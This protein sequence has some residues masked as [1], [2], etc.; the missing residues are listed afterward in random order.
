MPTY[1]QDTCDNSGKGTVDGVCTYN[2]GE[3]PPTKDIVGAGFEHGLF[4]LRDKFNDQ[5][6][7][8]ASFRVGKGSAVALG[9]NKAD[10]VGSA[11]KGATAWKELAEHIG[12]TSDTIDEY[13][14]NFVPESSAMSAFRRY[15]AGFIITKAKQGQF[16]AVFP[17]LKDL[18]ILVTAKPEYGE[19]LFT[20]QQGKFGTAVCTCDSEGCNNQSA[21]DF[22]VDGNK[23]PMRLMQFIDGSLSAQKDAVNG[24][25]SDLLD[26]EG[27][28]NPAQV[29]VVTEGDVDAIMKLEGVSGKTNK[30][31]LWGVVQ[32]YQRLLKAEADYKQ[33]LVGDETFNALVI[34]AAKVNEANGIAGCLLYGVDGLP[35]T[36]CLQGLSEDKQKMVSSATGIAFEHFKV[37]S[38][39][40]NNMENPVPQEVVIKISFVIATA[41]DFDLT[42]ALDALGVP[43]AVEAVTLFELVVETIIEPLPTE[44]E[45]RE[46]YANIFKLMPEEVSIVI[47]LVS[48]SSEGSS[49]R[50]QG[51]GA[52]VSATGTSSNA[53]KMDAAKSAAEDTGALEV[54]LKA[55]AATKFAN[56][57]TSIAT[58]PQVKAD[59][60]IV[61]QVANK[62][63]A[64]ELTAAF[65][66]KLEDGKA[67]I[68]AAAGATGADA[69]TI[70]EQIPTPMPT[71]MPTSAP[72]MLP[73]GF[74]FFPTAMPTGEPTKM[75]TPMPTAMP[76]KM[77]TAMPTN[78]PTTTPTQSPTAM[79]TPVPP[80]SAPTVSP[81]DPVFA[82]GAEQIAS[83][84]LVVIFAMLCISVR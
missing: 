77:P 70:V 2:D 11:C 42:G 69:S 71:K 20:A 49:R 53:T 81:T 3:G 16:G 43:E 30:E 44:Q 13:C 9:S 84:S 61:Q 66:K 25:V 41:A 45:A 12:H 21:L 40:A 79:P 29:S 38:E 39:K 18:L 35:N 5:C 24:I 55:T 46:V 80:T 83:L 22:I 65:V 6:S 60:Q 47:T 59:L 58:Q 17:G 50:L 37:G 75:P 82:A 63:A 32:D 72:T 15:S 78:G 36:F 73:A 23:G 10:L 48:S 52:L 19:C 74:T 33:K 28:M 64:N 1:L 14:A 57:T 76:T 51:G 26:A 67:A 34:D 31:E 62:N 56:V 27:K 68:I 4:N 7:L 8:I 54:A